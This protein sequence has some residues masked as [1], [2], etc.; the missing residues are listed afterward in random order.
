MP[1]RSEL[2]EE[3]MPVLEGHGISWS[4]LSS[5]CREIV[6]FG[7]RAVGVENESSD[8]DLLCV[9]LGKNLRNESLELLWVTPEK[10]NQSDWLGSELASHIASYGVWLIGESKWKRNVY[11]SAESIEHKL[12]KL[13]ARLE[14][15]SSSWSHLS[16]PYRIEKV[17]TLRRDVQRLLLLRKGAA[18]P[19]NAVL[20]MQWDSANAATRR[21]VES[22]IRALWSTN[23]NFSGFESFWKIHE[24]KG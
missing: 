8:W 22:E 18:I 3:I 7:S 6:L 10:T 19:A 9:G 5:Q 11:V 21:G 1:D 20:D 4:D 16:H 12:K 14:G 13:R 2:V 23:D 17:R 24:K 15:Y